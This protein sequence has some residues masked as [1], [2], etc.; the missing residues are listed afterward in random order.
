MLSIRTIL[1]P[2]DFSESSRQ[3]FRLACTLA[4][5]HRAR[6]IVMHVIP[7]ER[8]FIGSVMTPPA[9]EEY[10]EA[11]ETLGQFKTQSSRVK[12]EHRLVVGD[13]V[14]EICRVAEEAGARLIVMGTHGRSGLNRF[15]VGSVAEQVVRKAP[16]PVL[17]VRAPITLVRRKRRAAADKAAAS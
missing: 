14:E 16:C 5:D 12:L 7:E 3:A 6:L 1:H 17:T 8:P 11:R 9:A 4:A 13:P 2:T 15:F 10:P